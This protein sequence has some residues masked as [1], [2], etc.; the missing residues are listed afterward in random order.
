MKKTLFALAL[1]SPFGFAADGTITFVGKIAA[2]SCTVVGAADSSGTASKTTSV[3]LPNISTTGIGTNKGDISGVTAFTIKLTGCESPTATAVKMRVGFSGSSHA[4]NQYALANNAP[5][6][7]DVGVQILKSD[8]STKI[9]INNGANKADET[10]LPIKDATAKD[11]VLT[12]N[13]AYVNT[14]GSTVTAGPVSSTA[15]YVIEYN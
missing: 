9:D 1:V 13:A 10:T 8:G 12:F 6:G 2:A 7:S 15:N 14:T 3:A 4:N 5:S 11:Y